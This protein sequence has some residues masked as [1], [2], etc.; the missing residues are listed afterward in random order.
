[1]GD[2]NCKKA[3][4]LYEFVEDSNGF[5]WCPVEVQCRS[6]MN[7]PIRICINGKVSEVT[8]AG[9][10]SNY[11]ILLFT[12]LE[13]LSEAEISGLVQLAGHRS[14]G[15]IRVSMYNAMDLLGIEK[16]VEFMKAF[17]EKILK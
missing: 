10:L 12:S 17:A 8:E 7:V 5:Y 13:F 1:M 11:S 9:F 15:G 4:L 14:V 16:L 6:R 3:A 2:L